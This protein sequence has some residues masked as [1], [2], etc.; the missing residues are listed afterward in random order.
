MRTAILLLRIFAADMGEA[1]SEA[2][3]TLQALSA[4]RD[5]TLRKL[6]ALDAQRPKVAYDFCTT[7][8]AIA[9]QRWRAIDDEAD[10]L[11]ERVRLFDAAVY[12]ARERAAHPDWREQ[13]RAI[14]KTEMST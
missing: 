7:N 1:M 14:T 2:T 4:C 13:W 9:L 5:E 6:T 11:L 8:N 12:E 10:R 3:L